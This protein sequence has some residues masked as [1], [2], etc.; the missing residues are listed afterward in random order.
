M[1]SIQKPEMQDQSLK[2]TEAQISPSM[3]KAY[4]LQTQ[5]EGKLPGRKKFCRMCQEV[6][7]NGCKP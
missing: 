1:K 2:L 5:E 6:H 7:R 4:Q 3:F